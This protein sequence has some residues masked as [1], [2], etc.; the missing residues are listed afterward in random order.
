MLPGCVVILYHTTSE[1]DQ[2]VDTADF[3]VLC[4]TLLIVVVDYFACTLHVIQ[5]THA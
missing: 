3:L 4:I 1:S 2:R 5:K